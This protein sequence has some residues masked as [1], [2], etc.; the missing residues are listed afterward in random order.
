MKCMH[1]YFYTFVHVQIINCHHG[2]SRKTNIEANM[3][4]ARGPGSRATCGGR[5]GADLGFREGGVGVEIGA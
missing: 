2:S 3:V 5:A 4:K 1:V